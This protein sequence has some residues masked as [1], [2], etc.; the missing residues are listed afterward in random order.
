[1]PAP[2]PFTETPTPFLFNFTETPT[3]SIDDTD[4]AGMIFK[5]FVNRSV[6]LFRGSMLFFSGIEA[7]GEREW[8]NEILSY[9]SQT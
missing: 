1:M 5:S 6:F 7:F 3:P 4:D 8:R 9:L 2:S